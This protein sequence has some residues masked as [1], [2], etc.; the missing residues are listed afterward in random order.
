MW[1]A[2][3]HKASLNTAKHFRLFFFPVSHLVTELPPSQ[4]WSWEEA[5]SGAVSQKKDIDL[6]ATINTL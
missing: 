1:M 2:I 6:W 5:P 3:T 4:R